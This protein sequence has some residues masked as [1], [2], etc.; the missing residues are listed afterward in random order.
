M[1][2]RTI[3]RPVAT[4]SVPPPAHAPRRSKW[5]VALLAAAAAI[6]IYLGTQFSGFH[7]GTGD[8]SGQGFRSPISADG[9]AGENGPRPMKKDSVDPAD[10]E[11]SENA[12][13]SSGEGAADVLEVVIDGN[14]FEVRNSGGQHDQF[15][16]TTLAEIASRAERTRGNRDGVKVRVYRRGPAL[17]SAEAELQQ[18]LDEVVDSHTVQLMDGRLE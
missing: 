16:P 14:R 9:P 6:G 4:H 1:N 5:F 15:V 8:G 12:S 10:R 13:L 3:S 2:T 18:R 7:F 17:P 11:M